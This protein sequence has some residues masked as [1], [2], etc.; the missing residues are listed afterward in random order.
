MQVGTASAV[1][2]DWTPALVLREEYNSNV[3]LVRHRPRSGLEHFVSPSV[4]V[5]I[6]RENWRAGGRL[7]YES[8]NYTHSDRLDIDTWRLHLDGL[9]N[10]RLDSW[11]LAAG[12]DQTPTIES[13]LLTS[14]LTQF[15]LRR[16]VQRLAPGWSRQLTERTGVHVDL[17]YSRVTYEG[18]PQRT[19][20]FDYRLLT[21]IA[22]LDHDWSTTDRTTLIFSG[23]DYRTI[24]EDVR[25]DNLSLGIVQ[26][27]DRGAGRLVDVNLGLY[28]SRTRV[29]RRFGPF[30]LSGD[31]RQWGGVLGVTASWRLPRT[32]YRLEL[33]RRVDPTG[34]GRLQRTDRVDG[35]YGHALSRRVEA[36][37]FLTL[38]RTRDLGGDLIA[39]RLDRRFYR[40]SP[41]IGWR[42]D[43]D[44][45]LDA[46]LIYR[47]QFYSQAEGS[48]ISRLAGVSLSYRP[49]GR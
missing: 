27:H 30:V 33:N 32:H 4:Q 47:I 6:A 8:R 35:G 13:E 1:L 10:R 29:Q 16:T 31:K 45:R 39:R 3:N 22:S 14:G 18:D 34:T 24:G 41:G 12:F 49:V 11:R 44:W 5:A 17:D 40:L 42:I 46:Y 7:A 36:R 19:Q 37:L 26:R 43:R 28:R 38:I 48:A 21:G 25:A 20:L 15:S 2:V 23:L 9:Y